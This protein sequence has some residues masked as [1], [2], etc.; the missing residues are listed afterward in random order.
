MDTELRESGVVY[1][2]DRDREIHAIPC[3]LINELLV[4]RILVHQIQC[5]ILKTKPW[6]VN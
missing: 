6:S 3:L 4:P 2:S 1:S 5:Y